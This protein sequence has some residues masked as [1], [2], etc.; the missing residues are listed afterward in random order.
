MEKQTVIKK[1]EIEIFLRKLVEE[2]Q[3]SQPY[4]RLFYLISWY[5]LWVLVGSW[6]VP[7]IPFSYNFSP[8]AEIEAVQLFIWTCDPSFASRKSEQFK[9]ILNETELSYS[10]SELLRLCAVTIECYLWS[11]LLPCIIAPLL[12]VTVTQCYWVFLYLYLLYAIWSQDHVIRVGLWTKQLQQQ[13]SGSVF[14]FEDRKQP[15]VCLTS[16]HHNSRKR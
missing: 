12:R 16:S 10:D 14:A 9:T 1:P 4:F 2:F 11:V 13:S 3:D 5:G 8:L 6:H 7:S 15:L